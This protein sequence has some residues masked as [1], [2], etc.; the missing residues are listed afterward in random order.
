M[1][2]AGVQQRAGK[3]GSH[4]LGRVEGGSFIEDLVGAKHGYLHH[5]FQTSHHFYSWNYGFYGPHF[6]HE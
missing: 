3:E 4:C 5:L 6:T 2:L 1:E